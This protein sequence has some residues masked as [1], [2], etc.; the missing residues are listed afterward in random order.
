MRGLFDDYARLRSLPTAARHWH[1][2]GEKAPK[3]GDGLESKC[4]ASSQRMTERIAS[5]LERMRTTSWA[6]TN[7][8]LLDKL[9]GVM[10]RQPSHAVLIYSVL[11]LCSSLGVLPTK[12]LL[13][14][15]E[16]AAE[17]SL[18]KSVRNL[19]V[20]TKKAL[21]NK[22]DKCICATGIIDAG[23]IESLLLNELSQVSVGAI[24]AL[25]IATAAVAASCQ[26]RDLSS[27]ANPELFRFVFKN[28]PCASAAKQVLAGVLDAGLSA[29]ERERQLAE[30]TRY[31]A[32]LSIERREC[33][34]Q[35][36]ADFAIKS[37]LLSVK[38]VFDLALMYESSLLHEL[39]GA[40]GYAQRH[41][42][43]TPAVMAVV[44]DLRL[45]E[46]DVMSYVQVLDVLHQQRLLG[47][48]DKAALSQLVG[49]GAMVFRAM[50]ALRDYG[51]LDGATLELIKQN[52]WL[53]TDEAVVKLMCERPTL[54]GYGESEVH[55]LLLILADADKTAAQKVDLLVALLKGD[56]LNASACARPSSP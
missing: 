44:L 16:N 17:A 35:L 19:L 2:S 55:E 51:M 46:A 9:C 11:R 13:A 12:S 21:W 52:A 41:G 39:I 32:S 3:H 33:F 29:A 26:K 20:Q 24:D 54:F 25:A 7:P 23:I 14:L 10:Q 49:L 38:Q 18:L 31:A 22:D 37:R 45:G 15:L 42:V 53:F 47:L 50:M 30:M 8:G 4:V 27:Y 5:M 48:S 56:D 6:E 36:M 28:Y 43:L 34:L 1:F 40:L